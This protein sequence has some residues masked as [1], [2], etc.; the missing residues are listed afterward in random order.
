MK[1]MFVSA[2]AD[3]LHHL[4]MKIAQPAHHDATRVLQLAQC[5][6]R[7]HR[8][9]T[10]SGNDDSVQVSSHLESTFIVGLIVMSLPMR[11]CKGW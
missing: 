4:V 11:S 7:S 1:Q 5:V 6:G 10:A 2:R 8:G 3:S 9:Q